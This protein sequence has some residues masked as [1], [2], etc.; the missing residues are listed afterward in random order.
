M[1]AG[2]T[3]KVCGD[4]V[5]KGNL[6]CGKNGRAYWREGKTLKNW[7]AN[8][9]LTAMSASNRAGLDELMDVPVRVFLR[10]IM[11]KP[12]KPRFN[13]PATKPDVDKLIRAVLDGLEDSI[14]VNDSRVTRIEAIEQYAKE[15]QDTGVVI[16]VTEDLGEV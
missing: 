13:R 3:F 15:G 11:P 7:Q 1:S 10:F 8:I 4:P 2:L 16:S 12:R 5:Q 14:F 9:R 6:V